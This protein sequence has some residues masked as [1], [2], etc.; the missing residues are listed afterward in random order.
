[1]ADQPNLAEKSDRGE[2]LAWHPAGGDREF[3][4]AGPEGSL[5]VGL[6]VGVGRFFDNPV[7]KSARP[8]FRTGDKDTT[9]E[10]HGP[11]GGE[12]VKEVVKVVAKP[13]YAVGKITVRSGLG[14]DG[15]S[16]TFMKVVNGKLDP[17][18]NYESEW[19]GGKGGGGRGPRPS[20]P[21]APAATKPQEG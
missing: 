19:V 2:Q 9:G 21:A 5:L 16:I 6:E 18:D 14:I 7:V 15:L 4:E 10:W 8:I 3:R 1:M 12:V 20:T 17:T 13:G 11:N